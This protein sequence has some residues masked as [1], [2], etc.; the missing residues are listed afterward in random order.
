MSSRI[1]QVHIPCAL[2]V[3]FKVTRYS[4]SFLCKEHCQRQQEAEL[5]ADQAAGGDV[6][7]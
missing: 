5:V 1:M 7:R 4:C 6:S 3:G 2:K